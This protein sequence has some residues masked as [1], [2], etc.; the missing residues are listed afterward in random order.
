MCRVNVHL[1]SRTA[2][3][4][5]ETDF[6]QNCTN[7]PP[8][9]ELLRGIGVTLLMFL[10]GVIAGCILAYTITLIASKFR[11]PS[12]MSGASPYTTVFQYDQ[13]EIDI[14]SGLALLFLGWTIILTLFKLTRQYGFIIGLAISTSFWGLIFLVWNLF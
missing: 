12:K 14:I 10:L 7:D 9:I 2:S 5:D 11:G 3:M 4:T 1:Q 8:S 6:N 13:V